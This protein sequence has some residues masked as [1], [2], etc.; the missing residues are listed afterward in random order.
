MRRQRRNKTFLLVLALLLVGV[1]YAALSS[2]LNINGTTKVSATIWDVHFENV[3]ATSLSNVTP[4]TAPSA[5]AESKVTTLTYAVTLVKP[6]DIYEFTVDVKNAGTLDAMLSSFTN[7]IKVGSGAWQA[8]DSSSVPGYLIYSVTYSDDTTIT[9]NS[10]LT[11]GS[12]KKIKIHVEFNPDITNAQLSEA[13]G[14]TIYF[15]V[16]M[17][18]V[19]STV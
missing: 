18:Y 12:S 2:N 1:G 13:A 6:G 10:K 9:E 16:A 8:V 7:Q 4:S 14:K 3:A 17:N 11:T 5:P 15:Q 19:Q